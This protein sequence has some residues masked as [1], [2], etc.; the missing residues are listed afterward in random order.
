M[1]KLFLAI[2]M[3]LGSLALPAH[4]QKAGLY[5]TSL[6]GGTNNIAATAT[7]T[8]TI[9]IP[10]GEF[11]S[12]GLQLSAK[13][14]ST[15]T[16]T[17]PFRISKSCDGG[18]SFESVPSLSSTITFAGTGQVTNIS[19]FS[20]PGVSHLRIVSGENTN[21]MAVTNILAKVRLKAPKVLHV[22]GTQ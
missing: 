2:V 13:P 21:A 19:V 17:L 10:V 3:S 9:D 14:L 12:V 6:N 5:G 18:S 11:D 4:A 15:S 22:Q 20:V 1:K 7:N 16:G 8:Y